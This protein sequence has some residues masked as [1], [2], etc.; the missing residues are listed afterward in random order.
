MASMEFA[1]LCLDNALLL[2]RDAAAPAQPAASEGQSEPRYSLYCMRHLLYLSSLCKLQVSGV[3]LAI[4][5]VI[6]F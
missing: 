3:R 4:I 1:A 6:F 2:L 5:N